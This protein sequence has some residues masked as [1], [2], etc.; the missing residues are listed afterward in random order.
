[1]FAQITKR[2]LTQLTKITGKNLISI[3][4]P[5]EPGITGLRNNISQ[6]HSIK[7]HLKGYMPQEYA[8]FIHEA[9]DDKLEKSLN[10]TN[11]SG[12]AIFY[13]GIKLKVFSLAFKPEK[14]L[15]NNSKFNLEQITNYFSEDREFYVL[16][17]SKNGN[18]LYKGN[19]KEL[20]LL[21]IKDLESDIK[22]AL[23][24]DEMPAVKSLQVHPVNS[25]NRGKGFNFHGHGGEKD[26]KK[27]MLEE[28]IRKIDKA[29]L[30]YIKDKGLPLI[31]VA[32]DY[33]QNA[34]RRLTKHPNVLSVGISTNPD[35]VPLL[36]LHKKTFAL[37]S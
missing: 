4:I 37:I 13:D 32:V 7:S 10:A 35:N 15:Q 14:L 6:L 3:Y 33:A 19:H 9:L 8:D 17:L 2:D 24:I 5:L 12:L 27:I 30:G 23:H 25:I 31:V 11:A 16:S 21:K 18:Q 29:I 20:E 36:E 26:I 28:Y 34:F 1:M 22:H